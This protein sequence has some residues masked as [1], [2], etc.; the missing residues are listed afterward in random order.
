M[1]KIIFAC[2]VGNNYRLRGFIIKIWVSVY[3]RLFKIHWAL[4]NLTRLEGRL[5]SKL[6]GGPNLFFLWNKSVLFFNGKKVR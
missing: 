1:I 2:S 6:D 5:S 3:E 4:H